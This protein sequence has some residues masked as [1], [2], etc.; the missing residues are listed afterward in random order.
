[1]PRSQVVRMLDED[2]HLHISYS[3]IFTYLACSLK[4]RFQY[5]ENRPPERAG[6]TLF[7]GSG[8]HSALE[9][10]YRTMKD[11]GT[12]EPLPVLLEL[13]EDCVSLEIDHA[14]VPVIYKREAPDR[15][16][17]IDLGKAMLTAFHE[18]LDL[19]GYRIVDV[20]APLAATLF[21][22]EGEATEYKLIGIID[23]MLMD[24]AGEIVV[25]DNKTAAKAKSQ[26]AVDDDLQFSAYAYLAAANKL[27]FPTAPIKCRMDTLLKTKA[28]KLVQYQTIRTAEDRKRFAKITNAILNGIENRV[29]VPNRSWLCADCQYAGACRNW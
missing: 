1:M 4:Y 16:S 25:V 6:S 21:T 13:Y 2:P 22:E 20:E 5:V 23:L 26:S 7:M 27:T 12:L 3:Q 19:T 24:D 18:S 8:I 28:P 15:Q 10:L 17:V 9:R 11:K 29:F 14:G